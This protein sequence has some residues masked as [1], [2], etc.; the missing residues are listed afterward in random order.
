MNRKSFLST[1]ALASAW[2]ALAK[3]EHAEM[4][5]GQVPDGPFQPDWESLKS[6]HCP[7]WYRDAKLGIRAHWRGSDP[8]LSLLLPTDRVPE[9]RH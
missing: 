2:A 7:D 1:R 4:F 8:P 9:V 3:P 5:R 6:Y